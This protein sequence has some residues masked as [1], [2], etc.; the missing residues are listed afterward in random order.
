MTFH[1]PLL[2]LV[3]ERRTTA[4]CA[5]SPLSWHRAHATL[6]TAQGGQLAEPHLREGG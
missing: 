5:V 6:F 3:P 2:E 1:L 4:S